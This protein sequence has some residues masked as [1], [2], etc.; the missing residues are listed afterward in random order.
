MILLFCQLEEV[1]IHLVAMCLLVY[2][3]LFQGPSFCVSNFLKN[4]NK[5]FSRK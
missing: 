3:E 1:E 5:L 2:E 4:I